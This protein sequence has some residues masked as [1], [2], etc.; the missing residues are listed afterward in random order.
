[1]PTGFGPAVPGL[2]RAAALL[3]TAAAAVVV[4][5]ASPIPHWLR[6]KGMPEWLGTTVLIVL[7]YTTIAALVLVLAVSVASLASLLPTYA[8]RADDLVNDLASTLARFGVGPDEIRQAA[9]GLDFDKLTAAVQS[10]LGAA[11]SLASNLVFLLSLLLFLSFESATV[12][13]RRARISGG[14]ARDQRGA[15]P[16]RPQHPP[17]PRRQHRLRVHRG[18][19]LRGRPVDP[20]HPARPGCGVCWAS[21]SACFR[22]PCSG[23]WRAAGASCSP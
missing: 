22:R 10:L 1:M 21:S 13:I 20:G 8:D 3:A 23:C 18:R 12:G 7:V 17:L 6:R 11:T 14:P 2:P 16:V 4:I 15:R 5:A 9:S 19:A